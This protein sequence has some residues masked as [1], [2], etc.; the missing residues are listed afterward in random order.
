MMKTKGDPQITAQWTTDREDLLINCILTELEK[1][2]RPN[3]GAGF[4]AVAW[5]RIRLRFKDANNNIEYS[6]QQLQSKYASLK[7]LF[8]I[9]DSV[10]EQSGFG[11]N[12]ELQIPTA[13]DDVWDRYIEAHPKADQFRHETLRKFEELSAIFKGKIA[14]GAM[15]AAPGT[16]APPRIPRAGAATPPI[17]AG[18]LINDDNDQ[19]ITGIA[20]VKVRAPLI[21]HPNAAVAGRGRDRKIH[22][23]SQSIKEQRDQDFQKELVGSLKRVL[24]VVSS[25]SEE[26]LRSDAVKK[27]RALPLADTL[28]AAQIKG[29]PGDES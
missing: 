25:T 11:W 15:A 28:C 7:S 4:K 16:L 22:A 24:D 10:C 23:S 26:Q 3:D 19:Q 27:F 6:K 2:G 5:N 14:S 13:P 1:Y 18:D 20:T 29:D 8:S 9:F 17:Q 12:E 21:V